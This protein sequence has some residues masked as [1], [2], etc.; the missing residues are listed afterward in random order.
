MGVKRT[1]EVFKPG[2]L[3]VDEY[4]EPG[5]GLMV[6]SSLLVTAVQLVTDPITCDVKGVSTGIFNAYC[7]THN[8]FTLPYTDNQH[9]EPGVGP[10][11]HHQGGQSSPKMDLI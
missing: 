6:A 11:H 7:W 3:V 8:T 5:P 1:R 4:R 9:I 10:H 2:F